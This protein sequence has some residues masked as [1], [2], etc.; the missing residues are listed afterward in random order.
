M[1]IS[2]SIEKLIK[3][4]ARLYYHVFS[5]SCMNVNIKLRSVNIFTCS[6]TEKLIFSCVMY[7]LSRVHLQKSSY[8]VIICI[9]NHV[10]ICRKIEIKL[11][12][13]IIIRCSSAEK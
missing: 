8:N 1:H 12:Y 6:S 7:I 10:F 5:C 2:S 9:Y 3:V 11:Q 13:V 4:A